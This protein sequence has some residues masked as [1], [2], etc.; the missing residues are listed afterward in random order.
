MTL[1][2]KIIM[3]RAKH[4]MT[5]KQFAELVGLSTQTVYLIESELQN[6]KKITVA[7]IEL[8]LKGD[9]EKQG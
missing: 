8:V 7:K 5:Q 2:E 6:P 9:E 4:N 1:G 3:Y